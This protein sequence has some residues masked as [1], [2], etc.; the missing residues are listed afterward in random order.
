MSVKT[1]AAF[2]TGSLPGRRY[3]VRMQTGF[4]KSPLFYNYY[5]G[6]SVALIPSQSKLVLVFNL[7][8]CVWFWGFF[9]SSLFLSGLFVTKP[10]KQLVLKGCA[11]KSAAEHEAL[12]PPKAEGCHGSPVP[13]WL[14]SFLAI[15]EAFGL[16]TAGG[17][18][19]SQFLVL[20][21]FFFLFFSAA[22]GG[23]C[24][25]FRLRESWQKV[26]AWVLCLSQL[27]P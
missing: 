21:P 24:L 6:V 10:R 7:L 2:V 5:V 17:S 13:G 15:H 27:L 19:Q 11:Q 16:R 23:E 20:L 9:F 8:L 1:V 4:W 26:V 22:S 12:S 14:G 18:E 3:L 25:C